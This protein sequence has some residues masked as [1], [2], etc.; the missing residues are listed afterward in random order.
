MDFLYKHGK[1]LYHEIISKY[2]NLHKIIC[3]EDVNHQFLS[4]SDS[5]LCILYSF[6]RTYLEIT[7][8]ILIVIRGN[9]DI[10]W[11]VFKS[12]ICSFS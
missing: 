3:F 5:D 9:F 10:L 12:F 7:S 11:E 8:M 4:N 2:F 6:K 1:L